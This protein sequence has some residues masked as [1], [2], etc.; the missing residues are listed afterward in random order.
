MIRSQLGRVCSRRSAHAVG[1]ADMMFCWLG[2]GQGFRTSPRIAQQIDCPAA[3]RH[4]GRSSIKS[5]PICAENP[6][7]W[8]RTLQRILLTSLLLSAGLRR[9]H[10]SEIHCD[11]VRGRGAFCRRQKVDAVSHGLRTYTRSGARVWT[12]F[13]PA[14][15]TPTSSLR[16]FMQ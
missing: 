2:I 16:M 9:G 11:G 5:V 4:R 7:L 3:G 14:Q 15:A 1:T 10:Q 12:A 8:R 13:S 6:S